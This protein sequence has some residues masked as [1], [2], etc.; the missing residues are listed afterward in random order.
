MIHRR[1]PATS[2]RPENP[3]LGAR[4]RDALT[5]ALDHV[6]AWKAVLRRDAFQSRCRATKQGAIVAPP[7]ALG[8]SP[9]AL[10]GLLGARG[11]PAAGR[12]L[13]G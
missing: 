11:R 6:P 10:A 1:R 7:L 9:C 4:A 12:L 5:R 13:A 3:G 2:S 8:A